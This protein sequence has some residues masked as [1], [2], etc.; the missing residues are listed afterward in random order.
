MSTSETRMPWNTFEAEKSHSPGKVWLPQKCPPARTIEMFSNRVGGVAPKP[1]IGMPKSSEL[2]V[3]PEYTRVSA[4]YRL[5]N[6][7]FVPPY[8]AKLAARQTR[9]DERFS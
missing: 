8:T 1:F 9:V 4:T 5:R 6:T 7:L 3:M 2:M